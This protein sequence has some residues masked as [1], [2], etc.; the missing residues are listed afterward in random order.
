VREIK[1]SK[2]VTVVIPVYNKESFIERCMQSLIDLDMDYSQFEA[3]FIDDVS[4]DNSYTIIQNYAQE[5]NFIK[6]TPLNKNTGDPAIPKNIGIAKA[7]GEYITLLDADDWLDPQGVPK[8]IYQMIEHQSDIGFGQ[9]YKHTDH[10]IKKIAR[11]SSFEEANNLIPYEILKFSEQSVRQ[12]K[13]LN[14]RLSL[15]TIFNLNK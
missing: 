3:I 2:L 15:T 11:F 12:I 7:Q 6:C 14:V 9:C 1:I 4:T 13:Y 8:L 5:Y 10:N